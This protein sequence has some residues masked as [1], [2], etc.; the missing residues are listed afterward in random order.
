MAHYQ[1][2]LDDQTIQ[3][4]VGQKDQAFAL[5]LQQVLNQVLEA[6]VTE[7]LQ[8]DRYE[9]TE[10]R[11]GYRNG[12]RSRQLTTRVGTLTL[13]VPRTR[14]GEFSPTLFERYQRHEK[15]L[16]LTLMEMVVNG[17]STRKIRR[18]TEELCGTEF[19]K[20]TVSDLAKGLEA[21]VQQWRTRSLAET[22]YPFLIV[23]ALVLKIRENGA[24]RSRSGCVVTGINAAGYRE[25]LGFWIGDSESKQTW[26]AVFTDLKDRGLTGV[27]LVVSDDHRGLRQAIEQQFQGA[28]WQRCQTHL[29]RNIL[30]AAPKAVQEELHGRLRALFEAPDRATVDTLWTKLLE[31]FAERAPRAVAILE[32]G[33]EDALA[34]L[35]LP[36][37][38]R[39]RLRTTNSVERL[40]AE[41]RRR[42]RVIRIFP[43]RESAIR[44]LGALLLEQHEVWTTGKRY[45]NLEPYWQAKRSQA[46]TDEPPHA[47][48]AVVA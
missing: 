48:P 44:L 2:T 33:L 21:A 16:V 18:V 24:V 7:H 6:E 1:I 11:R 47:G 36:E 41:I 45:L 25:I 32:N 17:V 20:S 22:P 8:A 29:T 46:A 43:N 15:A 10:D 26:T 12:S 4:L 27:D 9:R 40:N 5:L 38:L 37:S 3:A 28:S 30:D 14:D 23:D 42:E 39:Q 19:S 13:E 34:V 35:Q 31:D